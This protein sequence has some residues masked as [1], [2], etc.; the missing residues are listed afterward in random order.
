MKTKQK[1]LIQFAISTLILNLAFRIS[2]SFGIENHLNV[3][4]LLSSLLFSIMLFLAGWYFGVKQ[5][6]YFP[7]K[8]FGIRFHLINFVIFHSVAFSWIGLGFGSKY[9]N[10]FIT[11]MIAI[12]WSTALLLHLI[13]Y[14][15]YRKTR[16]NDLD[17]EDLFD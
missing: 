4:I 3:V 16:I 15:Y 9:E 5:R 10:L 17:K 7:M 14:F 1:Y 2:L 12:Y 8:D 6:S 13:M 11:K